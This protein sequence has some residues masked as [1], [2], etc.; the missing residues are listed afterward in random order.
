MNHINSIGVFCGSSMGSDPVYGEQAA[1]LGQLLVDNNI[2]LV[3][4]GANIGL[5]KV[6]ASTIISGGGKV[7]GVMP[8][9]LV[10]KE[11]VHDQL[12]KLYTVQS[13]HERKALMAKLSDAFIAMPGGFGTLDELA[14]VLTWYQLE[15]IR[16]PIAIFNING[17]FNHLI[18]F[19]DHS[20]EK[21]FLRPE[22]RSNIIIEQD[23][24]LLIK[25]ICEFKPMEVDSKW[26][27]EL[28]IM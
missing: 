14:E 3:Y 28:K 21:K 24:D 26:V 17:Y 25:K 12:T 9:F 19:L 4:G 27:D 20:V 2:D 8:D 15:I 5:M 18:S 23:P 7:Y 10:K 11:I 13:M 6:I 16:K 1:I 22:H